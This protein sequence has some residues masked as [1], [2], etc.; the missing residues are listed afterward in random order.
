MKLGSL[1]GKEFIITGDHFSSVVE[2]ADSLVDLMNK[3]IKLPVD[4][5][6]VKKIIRE[7]EALGGTVLPPG[8]AIPHGRVE[9][10]QDIL[11]GIWVP[12]TPLETDQGPLKILFFFI[13]SK[14]GSPLYLPVL[15]CIGKYFS[16]SEFLDSLMGKT[17]L[18]IHD[19]LNTM[20]LKKEITIEDIMTTDPVSCNEN[21][22]L[23]QLADLFYQKRLSFLP[24]V[25]NNNQLV[26]E[27][28]IKDLLSNGIPDYVKR[29]GNVKFMKTL[30]PFEVMLRDEDR[31][32]IKEIMRPINR[33]ISKDASILEAVILITTKGFRH[34]PVI[35]NEKLIGM[36]SETDI[37]QK[38]IRG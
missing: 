35:E 13:T 10:F 16:D 38:V 9:G 6:E 24:V 12:N 14:V 22:S 32:L 17:A 28:T 1:V 3:K 19:L 29:L 36:I 18:Q 33:G 8:V 27:V 37:L 11:M 31:I 21:M 26:G 15:S 25:N 23:A 2:A 4:S 34:I 20:Q 5:A 30:E 7:R